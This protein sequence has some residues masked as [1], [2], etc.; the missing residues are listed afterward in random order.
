MASCVT[1]TMECNKHSGEKIQRLCTNC[2]VFVC[3]ECV[4]QS[5]AGHV[6]KKFGDI[7]EEKKKELEHI[8]KLTND[9][10]VED[11]QKRVERTKTQKESFC[12][13]I[14]NKID[15][16]QKRADV[17]KAAVDAAKDG[18]LKELKTTRDNH[19]KE[20]DVAEEKLKEAIRSVR[21]LVE[22]YELVLK[23][24]NQ[25]SVIEC[26]RNAEHEIERAIPVVSIPNARHQ[27][28]VFCDI[29][30]EIKNLF[31]KF[32][33]EDSMGSDYVEC[34][35]S[36]DDGDP[37]ELK[38]TSTL[39]RQRRSPI[40]IKKCK[41]R[42]QNRKINRILLSADIRTPTRIKVGSDDQNVASVLDMNSSRA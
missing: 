17:L 19:V 25:S 15:M 29:G 32:E 22:G 3:L 11:L 5:H 13:D 39:T 2:N 1:D 24:E 36:S 7:M 34:G 20:F 12:E 16:V 30:E 4:S 6:F 28:F 8:V 33:D 35:G 21:C 23:S 31:A 14:Q 38:V 27:N 40:R 42:A 41:S 10:T 26:S 18:Y 37:S 9:E